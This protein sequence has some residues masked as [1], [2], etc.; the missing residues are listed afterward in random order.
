[1]KA[2]RISAGHYLYRGLVIKRYKNDRHYIPAPVRHIPAPPVRY[3]WKV[4]DEYGNYYA[5]L[6]TLHNAKRIVDIMHGKII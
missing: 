2:K 4:E 5:I 3:V 1:M 6:C